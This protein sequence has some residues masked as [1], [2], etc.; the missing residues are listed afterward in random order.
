[1]SALIL[2]S[3]TLAYIWVVFILLCPS[4]LETV[5]I[6]TPFVNVIVVANVCL[7]L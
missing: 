1:M 4:I 3:I 2:E 7:A 5:S 6:G